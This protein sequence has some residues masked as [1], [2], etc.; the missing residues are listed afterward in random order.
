MH[1]AAVSSSSNVKAKARRKSR[2]QQGMDFE[3]CAIGVYMDEK[4][5]TSLYFQIS[6][7]WWT[8]SP[9]GSLCSRHVADI[10]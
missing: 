8:N 3:V 10:I 1:T 5:L 2:T 7:F 6:E 9:D 4:M